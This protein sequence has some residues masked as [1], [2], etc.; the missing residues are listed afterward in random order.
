MVAK[1]YLISFGSEGY[2]RG[3][4]SLKQSALHYFNDI[5]LFQPKDIG[6]DFREANKELFK[7]KRG[8]GYW[9]WKP[10]FIQR[11]LSVI[12]EGDVVFYCDSLINFVADP[13]SVI[14]FAKQSSILIGTQEYPEKHYTK[15]DT[16]H[17]MGLTDP[18]YQDTNQRNASHQIY[19][20]NN[21]AMDFVS[22]YLHYCTMPQVV[23]DAVVM[24]NHPDFKDH[25]HDQSIVSL[26]H[27]KYK[28]KEFSTLCQFGHRWKPQDA[29]DYQHILN[30][31]RNVNV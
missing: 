19:V 1:K 11:M 3:L 6:E 13:A 22:E 31:H 23:S 9:V 17:L 24:P 25:R 8:Y 18:S 26:L 2:E 5:V 10:Y 15:Q 20:K 28:I 27:K 7:H 12:N 16:F 14:E 30:H 21:L 29:P 4:S